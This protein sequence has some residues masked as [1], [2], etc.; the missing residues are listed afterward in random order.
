MSDEKKQLTVGS[1]L[2]ELDIFL[3]VNGVAIN[4]AS[5]GFA[6]FD[7]ANVL[8]ASGIALNPEVGHYTASGTVPNG[9]TLGTW[10]IEWG[11]SP[12][13]GGFIQVGEHFSVQ[14]LNIAFGFSPPA[15]VVTSVFDAVRLDVGD[16]DGT[17]FGDEFLRRV[18]IKAV[19]RLNNKL[20]LGPHMRGPIGV[21][22]QFGGLRIRT[23]PITLDLDSGVI[24]P[25]GDEYSD[26][27][28]LQ[29]EYIIKTSE[30]S[31]L[32]RLSVTGTSGPFL[33]SIGNASGDGISVTNADNVT[34][35]ISSNRLTTRAALMRFDVE[36]IDKEL[37]TAVMR[38][39]ARLSSTFGKLVY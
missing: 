19:R 1:Q 27:L 5:V 18:L 25:P 17:I 37:E 2:S 8:A 26:L 3:S 7:A 28:I 29:M 35:A 34:V 33:A 10:E 13:G 30:I 6:V 15:E 38:Y 20:G 11:V 22:G 39:L 14:A 4:A 32:K 31:A 12:A 21:P 16:P 9:F 23:I 36:M 24:T